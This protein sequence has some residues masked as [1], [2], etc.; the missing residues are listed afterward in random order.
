MLYR[1]LLVCSFIKDE[2]LH[3][4]RY[5]HCP[6]SLETH[7]SSNHRNKYTIVNVLGAVK[8]TVGWGDLISV[9]LEKTFPVV[10]MEVS[11]DG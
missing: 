10:V 1:L 7:Y 5:G 4:T 9:E 8:E 6:Y 11:S 2:I 3:K